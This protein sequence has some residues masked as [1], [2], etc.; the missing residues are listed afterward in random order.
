MKNFEKRILHDLYESVEGLYAFTLYSRYKVEPSELFIF[1]EKYS[2]K[3]LLHFESDK[4]ELTNEG[5]K[6]MFKQLRKIKSSSGKYSNIPNEFIGD[7]IEI[8]SPYIPNITKLS[9]EILNLQNK[10]DG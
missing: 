10:G 4:L 8:D 3:G 2:N 9:K 5:K 7:K 1:I 6:T